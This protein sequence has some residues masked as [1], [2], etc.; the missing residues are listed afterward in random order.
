MVMV[1]RG[2]PRRT[3]SLLRMRWSLDNPGISPR[4]WSQRVQIQAE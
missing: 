1:A 2:C 3:D 4:Q